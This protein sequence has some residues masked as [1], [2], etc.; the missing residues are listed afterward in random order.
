[1]R[2]STVFLTGP[3]MREAGTSCS[4]GV[5]IKRLVQNDLALGICGV[6][7]HLSDMHS[8]LE[9]KRC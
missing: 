7:I 3:R 9:D 1:M 4:K 6:L 5:N 2:K 8:V